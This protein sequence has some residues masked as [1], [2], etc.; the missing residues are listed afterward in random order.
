MSGLCFFFR[1]MKVTWPCTA[2]LMGKRVDFSAR[3][4]I[5]PDPNLSINQVGVPRSIARTLTYPEVV[6]P[7]NIERLVAPLTCYSRIPLFCFFR[8]RLQELVRR[9]PEEYPGAVTVIR[10]NGGRLQLAIS[11]RQINLE[12]WTIHHPSAL[13]SRAYTMKIGEIVE[14]HMVDDDLVIFNRQPSLHKMSMMGHRVKVL[15]W[16]TF[17]LNLV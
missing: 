5:T 7:F 8:T 16:S 9:G 3:T 17:R 10:S 1:F 2:N 6:T 14:R 12:V 13:L 4:V 11:K 15:P